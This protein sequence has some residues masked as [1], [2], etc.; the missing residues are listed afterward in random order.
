MLCMVALIQADPNLK[1]A[2][3]INNLYKPQNI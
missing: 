1:T 3:T 2:K